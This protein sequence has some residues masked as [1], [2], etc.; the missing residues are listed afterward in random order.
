MKNHNCLDLKDGTEFTIKVP[1]WIFWQCCECNLVHLLLFEKDKDEIKITTYV[2][3]IKSKA[4]GC[5][6]KNI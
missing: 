4:A 1:G 5:K 2:D 3:S 6:R